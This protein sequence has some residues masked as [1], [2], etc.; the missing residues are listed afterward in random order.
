[1][2]HSNLEADRAR[3]PRERGNGRLAV[4]VLVG[5]K[6]RARDPAPARE[7]DLPESALITNLANQLPSQLVVDAAH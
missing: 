6:H 5:A 2:P 1:L 3:D 7:L 4:T